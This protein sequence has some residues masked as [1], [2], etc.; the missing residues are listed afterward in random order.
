[1]AVAHDPAPAGDELLREGF[2]ALGTPEGV[3]AELIEG[4]I[5]VTT[6]PDGNHQHTVDLVVMQVYRRS[7]TD[8]QCSGNKGLVL[9]R[10]GLCPKNYAIPDA[11]FA[12]RDLRLFRG[13][14][15]W[16]PADGVAMV[17]EVTSAKPDGDRF[18]K[19]HCYARAGIPLYLLIDREKGTVTLFEEPEE[20][21]Y[22][23]SHSAS[24]GKPM[25]LPEPFGFALD[26]SEFA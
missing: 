12:P 25:P 24:F 15:P 21:D 26:T 14:E 2:L 23:E 5:S 3:R 10:G 6:P 19:R 9:P 13:A 11:T 17:A 7:A 8:M 1:M 20:A 22:A 18:A 16:M 4:E